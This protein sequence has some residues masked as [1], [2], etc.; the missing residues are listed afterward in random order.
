MAYTKNVWADRDVQHPNRYTLTNV[1]GTT[2]DIARADGTVNV[3]GTLL[4]ASKM[5]NIENG[6]ETL[7]LNKTDYTGWIPFPTTLAYSSADS[8]T[9]VISINAD[10]TGI[11]GLGD[12][13][14]LTQTTVKY[15]IVT[16]VGAYSG[17][18]TLITV[19]G[20]TDYT[21]ISAAI[22]NPYYSHAKSPFGFPVSRSKWTITFSDSA[23]R[24]QSNPTQNAWVNI[25]NARLTVPIGDFNVSWSAMIR[26]SRASATG[27]DVLCT[28]S[29][30]TNTESDSDFTATAALDSA[31]STLTS[32]T[33]VTRQKDLTFTVKT[34][35]YLN[36]KTSWPSVG[37]TNNQYVII[38]A[39]CSYL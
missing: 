39:I 31:T 18:N 20:G 37:E 38:K 35:L 23:R 5:N 29:T 12:K 11:I 32:Q 24:T 2:Y 33:T 9:F 4:N 28:L 19:Y 21:L 6:I 3:A 26:A 7:D 16:A 34:P 36:T 22:T 13:I 17:G 8:P 30:G 1:S 14:K 25:N 10:A 15:F 27:V